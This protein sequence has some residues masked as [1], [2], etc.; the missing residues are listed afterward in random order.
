MTTTRD[1]SSPITALLGLPSRDVFLVTIFPPNP[2]H[3]NSYGTLPSGSLDEKSGWPKECLSFR[4][5]GVYISN[6]R[7][8]FRLGEKMGH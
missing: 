1:S 2:L 3:F 4:T 8:L 5:I 6:I 7:Y